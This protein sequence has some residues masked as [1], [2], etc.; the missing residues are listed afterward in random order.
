M[1]EQRCS[2]DISTMDQSVSQL[3]NQFMNM[4]SVCKIAPATPGLFNIRIAFGDVPLSQAKRS[5]KMKFS[6]FLMQ[7]KLK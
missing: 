7:Y 5:A 3:I 4:E 6:Q 1:I 2:E